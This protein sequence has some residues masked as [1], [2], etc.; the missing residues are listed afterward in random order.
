MVLKQVLEKKLSNRVFWWFFP[1][2]QKTIENDLSKVGF[3][4]IC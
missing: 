1:W 2:Y 3:D 4:P